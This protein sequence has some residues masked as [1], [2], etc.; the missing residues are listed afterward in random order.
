MPYKTD[1][2]TRVECPCDK[3]YGTDEDRN[4]LLDNC[5]HH[6]DKLDLLIEDFANTISDVLALLDNQEKE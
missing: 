3:H 5:P 6:K 4:H 2:E 1:K